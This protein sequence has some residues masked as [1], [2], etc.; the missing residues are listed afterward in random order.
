MDKFD[1]KQWLSEVDVA[2]LV[3]VSVSTLRS[4]RFKRVGI[5]YSKFQKSV[6]Y[7]L[8]DVVDYMNSK[9]IKF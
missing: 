5:P 2:K 7:S 8:S 4:H 3:G 6:R 9:K 1:P